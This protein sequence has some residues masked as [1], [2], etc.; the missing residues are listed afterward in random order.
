MWRNKVYLDFKIFLQ[1]Q[2][3]SPT[4]QVVEEYAKNSSIHGIKYILN[5]QNNRCE[6][7]FWLIGLI[8]SFIFFVILF[9]KIWIRYSDGPISIEI[10]P[11]QKPIWDIPF[12]AITIC[13]ETKAKSSE[14]KFKDVYR[15]LG[16][17]KRPFSNVT[18]DEYG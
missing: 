1:K 16:T 18:P 15:K 11:Y 2:S 4:Y 8:I 7:I 5:R 12:P 3:K 13:T 14:I 10:S 6:R 17:G 9:S